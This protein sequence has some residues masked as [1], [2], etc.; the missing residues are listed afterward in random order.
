MQQQQQQQRFKESSWT[1]RVISHCQDERDSR[2]H[3]GGEAS[4]VAAVAANPPTDADDDLGR[5]DLHGGR[6]AHKE[7]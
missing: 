7:R 1:S 6:R 2:Q 4:K 3:S 5:G